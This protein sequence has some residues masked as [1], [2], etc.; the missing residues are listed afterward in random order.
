LDPAT[1]GF[2][3]VLSSRLHPDGQG[4]AKP[5]RRASAEAAWR[6]LASE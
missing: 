3:V 6:M 2:V 4:D 5:L 1:R